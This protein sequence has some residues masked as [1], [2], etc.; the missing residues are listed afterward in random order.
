MT[1]PPRPVASRPVSPGPAPYEGARAPVPPGP[2]PHGSDPHGSAPEA[3]L[4]ELRDVTRDYPSGESVVRVLREVSLTI[5]KGEMVAIVGASGSGKSTLMN[6]L[7]CL[8]RPTGGSYR[9][10]GRETSRLEADEL[11]ALRRE[12]FG[13]VFQ[14]YHLLGELDARG[15]VEIPAIYAGQ[16]HARRRARSTALLE[17]L[18]M[19]DRLHHRPGQ[20]SGGQQQRVSIARAL[21]NGAEVILADEPTGALDSRSG[22]DVLGILEELHASGKTVILVT[23]DMSVANRAER[24]IEI[25]DGEIISDRINPLYAPT[26]T[27]D[28]PAPGEPNSAPGGDGDPGGHSDPRAHGT[29]RLRLLRRLIPMVDRFRE[30]FR[31]ATLSM[32]A[33]KL[34]TLL[35]MLGI[36]IG[37]ASVVCVV[38]LG[39][40][41]QQS[42]LESISRL[43]TNTLEIYPGRNFGDARSGR[44]TTLVVD[45]ATQ[46]ARQPWVAAVTPTV[47][48]SKPGRYS[49]TEAILQIHGVGHRYFDAKGI[50]L[51]K[52]T[53]FGPDAVRERSPE[54]VIDETGVKTFGFDGDPVGKVLIIGTV[55]MRIVGVAETRQGGFG[56]GSS[57]PVWMPYTAAQSRLTGSPT[58]TSILVRVD[59]ATPMEYAEDTVKSLLISRHSAEDFFILNTDDIRKTIMSTA[60]TMTVLVASIAMISLV[61]GGIG[62][63]NIM[64]VTVSE[65]TSEIGVRMAVGAR[66]S[67]ILQQFLIEAVLVCVVGGFLGTTLALALG[68]AFNRMGAPFPLVYSGTSI[69]VAFACSSL[70][71]IIFGYLPARGASRLDPVVALSRD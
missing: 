35:T 26:R 1:A 64:L 54:I 68:V 61:V 67:D 28:A 2:A 57:L 62:V 48:T 17:R 9:V 45:D 43:G 19:G 42:V 8:D 7:G 36:I 40:G 13:F 22:E 25:S 15:N 23:H 18:G 38:A 51:L 27:G 53:L 55:P 44:I 5:R 32:V 12:H 24:L 33:H 59:D 58:L 11:A 39:Q 60:R 21:M 56:A 29:G 47:T 41:S 52:G 20:L 37:I 63:M 66:R 71:G 34:R 3:P 69:I 50:K 4:I 30:A 10:D 49:S 70:I 6:I 31:M 65:R 46:L 16:P 14:R